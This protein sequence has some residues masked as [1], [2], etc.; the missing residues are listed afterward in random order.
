MSITLYNIVDT[1]LYSSVIGH[2]TT[3]LW[4]QISIPREEP[5]LITDAESVQINKTKQKQGV[6]F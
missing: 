4:S 6:P 5:L 3:A 1:N 2:D